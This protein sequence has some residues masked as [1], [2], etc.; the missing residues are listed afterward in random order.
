M[1]IAR[2]ELTYSWLE[3]AGAVG[4]NV[5]GDKLGA[6]LGAAVGALLDGEAVVNVGALVAGAIVGALVTGPAVGDVDGGSEGL[7]VAPNMV[8]ELVGAAG[9]LAQGQ[10]LQRGAKGATEQFELTGEGK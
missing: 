2:S 9:R 8:G 10:H 5:E 4:A 1:N 6:A 7:Q 3:M